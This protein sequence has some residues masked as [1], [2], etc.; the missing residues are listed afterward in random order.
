MDV[1]ARHECDKRVIRTKRA[2][3]T[4]LFELMKSKDISSITISELTACANV[5][6][7]T[8][9]THYKSIDDI[10]EEIENELVV[11]LMKILARIDRI[12]Y[13]KGLYQLFL[14]FHNLISVDFDYYFSV[15][16]I[17]VRGVLLTRLKAALMQAYEKRSISTE[18]PD[19]ALSRMAFAFIAGGF[20]NS[21]VEWYASGCKQPIEEIAEYVSSFSASIIKT[22]EASK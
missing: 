7:R 1:A 19:D 16:R 3:K 18:C 13:Q 2:I 9:Y 22:A 12:D 14:D 20:M 10:F 5:N 6:R 4:A 11:A 15:I 17:D 21:Y 8:F